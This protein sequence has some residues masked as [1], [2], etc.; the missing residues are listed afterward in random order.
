MPF[1][2]PFQGSDAYAVFSRGVLPR[3]GIRPRRWRSIGDLFSIDYL[4]LRKSAQSAVLISNSRRARTGLRIWLG[5]EYSR[6]AGATAQGQ[7][8]SRRGVGVC[9][10]AVS[11]FRAHLGGGVFGSETRAQG[12]SRDAAALAGSRGFAKT[13]APAP[14]A[15]TVAGTPPLFWADGSTRWFAPRLV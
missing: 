7:G 11:G 14:N 2:S 1:R 5:C 6:Q 8:V 9:P 10:G 12:G 15:P 3:A 4:N 13:K